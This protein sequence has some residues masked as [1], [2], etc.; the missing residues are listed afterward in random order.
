MLHQAH[1]FAPIGCPVVDATNL[2]L[3]ALGK[4]APYHLVA[5]SPLFLVCFMG[6]LS[7]HHIAVECAFF[8]EQGRSAGAKSMR[9]VVA[10]GASVIAH[11]PQ[12]LVDRVV[13]HSH[14]I[15]MGEQVATTAG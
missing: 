1:A 5:A 15:V 6:E 14:V 10:A 3:V 13:G 7:F 2:V 8:V 12:G 4:L 11:D 9:A